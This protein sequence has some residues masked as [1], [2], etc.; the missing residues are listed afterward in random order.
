MATHIQIQPGTLYPQP[1]YTV[2]VDS[3]G[4]WG[5][6]QVFLCHRLSAVALMPRPGS[7]HPEVPFARL[8]RASARVT[9]GDLAEITCTY[10]GVVDA[11]DADADGVPDPE[12]EDIDADGTPNEEDPDI[13][14]DGVPN[15]QDPSPEGGGGTGQDPQDPAQSSG[16]GRPGAS[17]TMGVTM[18]EEPILSH[19]R[20]RELDAAVLAAVRMIMM[21]RD[22]DDQGMDLRDKAGAGGGAELLAKIDRGQTS[23]FLPRTTWRQSLVVSWRSSAGTSGTPGKIGTPPG[24]SPSLEGGGNWLLN[25]VTRT[26][27]NG[28]CRIEREWIASDEGGWDP[29]IYGT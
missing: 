3:E 13:D 8:T 5:V 24:P 4:K 17:Y 10:G 6:T 12:D 27:E 21:G 19:P 22:K 2:E 15:Q 26:Y 18:S 20:Y 23:Y 16:A 11:D 14:G 29:D 28:V 9:E 25:G 1:D 7:A